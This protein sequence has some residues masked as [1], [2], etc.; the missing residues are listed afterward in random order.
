MSSSDPR[1]KKSRETR[2]SQ[3]PDRRSSEAAEKEPVEVVRIEAEEEQ[4]PSEQ[5]PVEE[6]GA[7]S[8]ELDDRL[9][10]EE[11][12]RKELEDRLLSLRAEFD[13][14]RKRQAREFRRLCDKGKREIIGELLGVLDNANRAQKLRDEGHDPQEI[15]AGTFQTFSQLMDTLR[16][17]G[18]EKIKVEESDRFDPNIHEAMVAEDVEG[19]DH[20]IVLEVLQD[21]YMLE[22]E[23][24]RPTRVRVGRAVHQE[25]S[26]ER[27]E[28]SEEE[29]EE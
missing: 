25:E 5:V 7:D 26:G 16:R 10:E 18:L 22:Q 29:A 13:N 24:L 15:L 6:P 12:K 23:L 1:R 8:E 3:S 17:E 19:I 27:R 4:A 9:Q 20:D 14:Y 21:G 11:K 28:D 2:R